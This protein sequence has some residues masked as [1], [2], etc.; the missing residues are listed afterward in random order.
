MKTLRDLFSGVLFAA[1]SSIL[2][3]GAAALALVE[4]GS[5][6]LTPDSRLPSFTPTRLTQVIL[7]IRTGAPTQGFA[8]PTPVC[9]PPARWQLYLIQPGDTLES[10]AKAS[11]TSPERIRDKNCLVSDSLPVGYE[12]YLPPPPD[13]NPLAASRTPTLTQTVYR[14]Q[15]VCGP[16][17][18]WVTTIV[19]PGETLSMLSRAYN[20]SL[21]QLLAANCKTNA[22]LIYAGETLY[23]PNVPR[24][25]STLAAASPTPIPPTATRTLNPPTPTVAPTQT[26]SLPSPTNTPYP[27][28]AEPTLEG[29]P[30]GAVTNNDAQP[31]ST[32]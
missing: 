22:D 10:L 7:P 1:A 15:R 3:L 20:I 28:T 2:V 14:T 26:Y 16:P 25:T 8:T 21:D 13:A 19:Q 23:V 18:G 31:N 9:R 5:L 6:P 29:E 11:G 32:P 30:T 4:T 24:L 12:L 17:A 27:N